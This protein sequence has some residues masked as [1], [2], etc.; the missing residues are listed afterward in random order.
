FREEFTYVGSRV[1]GELLP[2]GSGVTMRDEK[3]GE[4]AVRIRQRNDGQFVAR[5]R[6]NNA[7]ITMLV[8]TGASTVVLRPADAQRAGININRLRFT[9]PV[10]TANGTTFAAP[11]NIK[12]LAVG[13]IIINDV[14]ALVSKPGNL[15]VSLLGMT[16]LRR[17]RSYNFSGSFLTLRS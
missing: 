10:R 4:V 8:D 13:P 7:N 3:T 11:I 16:F 5:T 12:A 17:L 6:V 15:N 1:A 9:V 2:A 14:D